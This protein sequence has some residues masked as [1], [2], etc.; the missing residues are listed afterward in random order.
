MQD[1]LD[2]I[3]PVTCLDSRKIQVTKALL[4]LDDI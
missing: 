2:L 1:P 4:K 3:G